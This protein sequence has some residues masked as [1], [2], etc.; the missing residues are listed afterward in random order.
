[1][2]ATR[3]EKAVKDVAGSVVV[4]DEEQIENQMATDISEVLR[5]EPGVTTQGN[6]RLGMAG[7]NIRGMSG[8]RVKVMVD[9]VKLASTYQSGQDFLRPE[10]DFVD[11]DSLK[12]VEIVKGPGSTLYGSDAMGGVVAF[13]TKSP[14]DLLKKE[15]DDFYASAKVGYAGA[16]KGFSESITF[17]NRS[18]PLETLLTYTRRDNKAMNT[19]SG[20]DVQGLARGKE[21]S[22]ESGLNNILAEARYQLSPDQVAGVKVDWLDQSSKSDLE[23]HADPRDSSKD[24]RERQRITLFHEWDA[25]NQWF[26][27]LHSQLSWQ[28]TK[29]N[30]VTY[31]YGSA[32]L[33]DR[34][35]DYFYEQGGFQL[36]TQ[37]NKQISQGNIEHFLTYGFSWRKDDLENHNRTYM[38]DTGE[39]LP[40]DAVH[41]PGRYSPL[42]TSET[43]GIFLQDEISFS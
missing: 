5:Y 23:A 41:Q 25:N 37:F 27:R 2:T 31:T 35:K 36:G 22:L 33:G 11:I 18:G 8:N 4:I 9:G 19:H 10:Q 16:N 12:A 3:T 14:G 30:Q 26:D 15:G 20:D 24:A 32:T 6:S 29:S 17:A 42:A 34:K 43:Y 1:M 13:V 39:L 38:V 28:N 40:P 7:F 21:E